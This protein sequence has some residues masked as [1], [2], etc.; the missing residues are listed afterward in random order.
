M[1]LIADLQFAEYENI[2]DKTIQ[3]LLTNY[4]DELPDWSSFCIFTPTSNLSADV[5]KAILR[6]LPQQTKAIIPPYIGTLR[7]WIG[8]HITITDPARTLLSEQARRL[9][10][11]D[12]LSQHP[13]LFKEENKWQV[14]TALLGLFD[15]LTLNEI[16]LLKQ[17]T[18]EWMRTL[19][20]AYQCEHANTHLQQEARLI[21]TLWHAWQQQLH[22]DKLFD[23]SS[24]YI[25]RLQ[26]LSVLLNS[27]KH[28]FL[29]ESDHL[30]ACEQHVLA[31]FQEKNMCTVIAH[32]H[33]L[34][35]QPPHP[36][37]STAAF[38]NTAFDITST[39]LKQRAEALKRASPAAA[40]PFS[41]FYSG[42]A[43][44]EARAIDLQIRLW[45]LQGKQAIAIVSEDRKLCRR[46]R[47]LLERANITIQDLAGWSLA[48]TSAAAVLERWLECIEEDFDY[49]PLLDLLKSHFFI[50]GLEHEHQLE[51]VY[52]LENDIIL[53]ENISH[54]IERYRKHLE[55][56][57]HRLQHWPK[58]SY[59][60]IVQILEQIEK[61]SF[62]LQQLY[63]TDRTTP[64]DTYINALNSSLQQLG[65]LNAFADDAAGIQIL[66]AL[67]EMRTGLHHC[68]PQMHW[69][70]FR[71]WL[72]MTMEQQ[73][74][75]PQTNASAVKLMSLAQAQCQ[76]FDALVIAAADKQHLPGKPDAS[77][78]FNQSVRSSLGLPDW[79]QQRQ[80][81]LVQF[82]RLLQSSPEI[83]VTCKHEDNGEPVPLSPWIEALRTF[84]GLT[85]QD[86]LRNT[87][88]PQLLQQDTSVF[89]CDTDKLPGIPDRPQPSMPAEAMPS[90][91]SASAH[92]RMIDCP[93][94]YFAGDGMG[95]K[96]PDE[97]K[98]ELQ[99]SDYGERIHKIL[100]A[101]HSPVK[102]LPRPYAGK[103]T[104]QK[105]DQAIEHL[106]MIST[107][108]FKQD[109]EDNT[110]HRSWLY[111]WM[112]HI[113]AY[114]DWQ[115]KQQQ[116]WTVNRTEQ[117]CETQ[118]NESK[119]T[120][121]GRLDRIDIENDHE[122]RQSIIDYKT[123][124]M[125]RQA[126]VD[127][128]EDVQLAT[129]A[130]LA[131]DIGSV[132]Y[133]S[134]DES[135]GAVKPK[136]HLEGENLHSLTHDVRD[137][138]LGIIELL[139]K[140]QSL[141]AWG[142]ERTCSYCDLIGLCRKKVWDSAG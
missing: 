5:R 116:Q 60:N 57:L 130:L 124:S 35:S 119:L 64:L 114:I 24:A 9:L 98:E 70:D 113:P 142:D 110:L 56:R 66:D 11:I 37:A 133:L 93:Y 8:E 134:L 63:R 42:D 123:G 115:I 26:Q 105:R 128:G 138:L 120:L 14:S 47:A 86:T 4:Q 46:V 85:H 83:L 103:L 82:R 81:K 97:I 132:M 15:E 7:Q 65:I 30:T 2:V 53:H 19:E 77:P 118:L 79:Q 75:S 10:F 52:R 34:E 72:G 117:L 96:P 22:D 125:A 17:S 90:R 27:D 25:S 135:D 121:H 20:Q 1:T 107:A 67:E 71:T 141:P 29:I 102:N 33:A 18:D 58:D 28:F 78:F 23:S 36:Q 41:I 45:L 89:I 88:L 112:Q 122:G 80:H 129:Y 140:G 139:Q 74:F 109:M 137:R 131:K 43:E 48:T 50:S 39:P 69:H 16:V 84:H 54:G 101:F 100:N 95:L 31:S 136:A 62:H 38:I 108:V 73:L 68:N 126:E 12:A 6:G 3:Y 44:S 55:Y 99:K 21:Y 40:L 104:E 32:T 91:M 51:T 59:D 94:K 13:A 111:R 127:S 106:A 92:Q 87:L 49:R 76:Q 61:A